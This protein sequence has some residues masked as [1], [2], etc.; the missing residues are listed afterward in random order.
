MDIAIFKTHHGPMG[1][2]WSTSEFAVKSPFDLESVFLCK[3]SEFAVKAPD[4]KSVSNTSNLG[5]IL[6]EKHTMDSS[7]W[8]LFGQLLSLQ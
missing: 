7:P 1:P 8:A 2:F 4:L 5:N 3:T 6:S